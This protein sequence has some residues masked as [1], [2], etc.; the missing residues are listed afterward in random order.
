VEH[1]G[2]DREAGIVRGAGRLTSWAGSGSG[3]N[4]L[5]STDCLIFFLDDINF[6]LTQ[7]NLTL[8]R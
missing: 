7:L 8:E 2:V 5:R 1:T 6:D 4:G 3:L